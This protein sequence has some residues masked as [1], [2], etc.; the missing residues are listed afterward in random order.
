MGDRVRHLDRL[1][2]VDDVL[3]RYLHGQPRSLLF[4]EATR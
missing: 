1:I 3:G 4:P 2:A